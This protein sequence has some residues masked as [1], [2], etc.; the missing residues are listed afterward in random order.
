[1]PRKEKSPK[2]KTKEKSPTGSNSWQLQLEV[3][4]I[5]AFFY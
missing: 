3:I 1:M 2:K 4:G 5:G